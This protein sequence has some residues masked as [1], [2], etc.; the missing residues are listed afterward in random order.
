MSTRGDF[1]F[2]E[3]GKKYF[4]YAHYD[5]S[6]DWVI[7]QL[8]EF[9]G[10][11]G[12]DEYVK[13]IKEYGPQGGLRQIGRGNVDELGEWFMDHKPKG[14][15]KS[16]LYSDGEN[17]YSYIVYPD[18]TIDVWEYGKYLGKWGH[19]QIIM[20]VFEDYESVFERMK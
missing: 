19:R 16:E 6:P 20:A 1:G 17:D 2:I 8:L 15:W 4:C 18:S 10:R 12:Y 13:Q 3:G 7:P 5:N 11:N 14:N 9:L